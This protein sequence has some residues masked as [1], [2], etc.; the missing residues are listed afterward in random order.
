[1]PPVTPFIGLGRTCFFTWLM[2]STVIR[3]SSTRASTTPRLPLSLPAIT[4]T[5]SPLRIR[6][7]APSRIRLQHFRRQRDDLH[8]PRGANHHRAVDLAFFHAPARG[9]VLDGH[10]D[11]VADVRIATLA[12]AQHLD[13][14]HGPRAGVV[15]DIE[16]RL[17]LNHDPSQLVPPAGDPRSNLPESAIPRTVLVPFGKD[18]PNPFRERPAESLRFYRVCMPGSKLPGDSTLFRPLQVA[19]RLDHPRDRPGLGL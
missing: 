14:H 4:T 3:R 10:L 16:H 2:P 6:C 1:M 7:I 11:H 17:H 13:T 12:A 19:G 5:S 8:E 18:R 15:G 9:G